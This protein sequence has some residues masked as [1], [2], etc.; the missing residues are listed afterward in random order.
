MTTTEATSVK[1]YPRLRRNLRNT[2]SR[3][4]A[5][6]LPPLLVEQMG[7]V[8]EVVEHQ[9]VAARLADLQTAIPVQEAALRRAEDEHAHAERA[10][11]KAGKPA[12]AKAAAK[13]ESE[14]QRLEKLTSEVAMV[15]QAIEETA[16]A[17]LVASVPHVVAA[18]DDAREREELLLDAAEERVRQALDLLDEAGIVSAQSTWL[19]ALAQSGEAAPFGVGRDRMPV[20]GRSEVDGALAAVVH[21]RERRAELVAD[22]AREAETLKSVRVVGVTRRLPDPP[23]AQ[24]WHLPDQVEA[25][26]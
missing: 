22:A 11:L 4:L 12:P 6:P 7:D 1:T 23:G 16:S 13:V 9:R 3:E 21:G 2:N 17:L 10:A 8:R 25:S 15:E 14:R 19:A 18:L 5:L 20:R 26:A 24:V